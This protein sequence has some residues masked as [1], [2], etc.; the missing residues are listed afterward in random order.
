MNFIANHSPEKNESLR[1]VSAALSDVIEESPYIAHLKDIENGR[2]LYGND[3]FNRNL[4]IQS[5]NDVIGLNTDEV[6]KDIIGNWASQSMQSFPSSFIR[7]KD[8]LPELVRERD[9][10]VKVAQHEIVSDFLGFTLEGSIC[11]EKKITKPIFGQNN[12]VVAVLTYS[13]DITRQR[14]LSDL[15]DLYLKYYDEP[16]QATQHLLIYLEIDGYFTQL[17]TGTEL[18]A[19]FEAQKNP[20]LFEHINDRVNGCIKDKVEPGYWK[21]M[22]IRLAAVSMNT[23]Q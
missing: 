12:A 22:C 3:K 18:K 6:V 20:E 8:K 5:I 2:Y 4:G 19:L 17:P 10:Q 13:Q 21:E 1:Y 9:H 7:W 23:T 15:F 11:I 14:S 16:Q